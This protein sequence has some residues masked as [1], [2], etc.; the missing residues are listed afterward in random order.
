MKVLLMNDIRDA[1]MTGIDIPFI[2]A[3]LII[4]QPSAREISQIG[5]KDYFTGVQMLCFNKSMLDQDEKVLT[6]KSNFQIFMTVMEQ[7]EA[8][9]QKDCVMKVFSLFFPNARVLLTPRTIVV[10]N[11]MIDENNFESFQE[12]LKQ[13]CCLSSQLSQSTSYNPVDKRA[14]EIA[15]KLMK[16]REKIAKQK[17][18]EDSSII[19]QYVSTIAIGLQLSVREVNE[20]TLYQIFDQIERYSLW[21]NWDLDIKGRLAGA[22]SESKPDNWMK[23]IH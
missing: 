23:N 1:L 15:D 2:E 17:G 21:I 8:K 12:I 3:Q 19:N 18:E 5:E 14:K 10:D 13:I 9:Q 7:E 16:A 22:T 6:D 11:K 4:H 20:Y